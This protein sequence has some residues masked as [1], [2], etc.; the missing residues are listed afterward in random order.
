MRASLGKEG[1]RTEREYYRT[2]TV[3]PVAVAPSASRPER[4][5][6]HA[7]A[8]ACERK[9]NVDAQAK[10]AKGGVINGATCPLS[11]SLIRLSW[12]WSWRKRGA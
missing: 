9:R 1:G 10:E 11:L 6:A 3:R 12:D 5:T 8:S 4:G 2:V 7:S